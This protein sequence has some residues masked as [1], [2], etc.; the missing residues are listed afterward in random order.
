MWIE[1]LWSL[2]KGDTKSKV[3]VPPGPHGASVSCVRAVEGRWPKVR[4]VVIPKSSWIRAQ[5]EEGRLMIFDSHFKIG[6]N[7]RAVPLLRDASQSSIFQSGNLDL[8]PSIKK[9]N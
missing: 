7:L 1:R 6:R 9:T 3:A 2:L 4:D 5:R 8:S